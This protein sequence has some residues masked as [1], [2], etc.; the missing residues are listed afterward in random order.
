MVDPLDD[1]AAVEG[2]IGAHRGWAAPILQALSDVGG[3]APPR[4]IERRLREI[5][6]GKLTDRQW[7]RVIR[8]K[9]IR[10]AKVGLK[11]AGLVTGVGRW[12]ITDAGRDYLATHSADATVFPQVQ[13]VSAAEAA[14]LDA[15]LETVP[16]TAFT[17]YEIPI[18]R[19]LDRAPLTKSNLFDE[20]AAL[21]RLQATPLCQRRKR[22]RPISAS[23]ACS[24]GGGALRALGFGPMRFAFS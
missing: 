15:P 14:G 23:G 8:G 2:L 5:S 11:K 21:E 1:A 20:G 10:W 7:A 18:L 6:A 9:Y 17:G 19:A 4:E 22:R 24:G 13:E 16:A 3:T 12:E